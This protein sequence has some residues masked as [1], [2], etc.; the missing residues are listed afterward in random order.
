MD[1]DWWRTYL[2]RMAVPA[3][4]LTDTQRSLLEQTPIQIPY[5]NLY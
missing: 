4:Y 3:D 5:W 1:A 2:F